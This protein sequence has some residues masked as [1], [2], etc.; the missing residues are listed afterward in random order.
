[1][2]KQ[3]EK[4][5]AY[6]F[7]MEEQKMTQLKARAV[8]IIQRIPEEK[9]TFVFNILQNIE[10]VADEPVQNER[11]KDGWKKYIGTLSDDECA[12]M[13]ATIEEG[14]EKVYPREW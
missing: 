14:C 6:D 12:E 8:D 7:I 4:Q 2:P 10:R 13:L 11:R 9:M 3:T 5:S 1:M